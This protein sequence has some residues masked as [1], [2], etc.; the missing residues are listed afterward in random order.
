MKTGSWFIRVCFILIFVLFCM[1]PVGSQPQLLYTL[2]ARIL[3][4][5]TEKAAQDILAWTAKAGGYFTVFSLTSVSIRIPHKELIPL[6]AFLKSLSDDFVQLQPSSRDV[7]LDLVRLESGIV[8]REEILERNLKLFQ[9][10]DYKSTL[11]I[12]KENRSLIEEIER[13]K[14]Q[15][16]ILKLDA[17]YARAEINLA[18]QIQIREQSSR[19]GFEWV[20]NLGLMR[21][22]QETKR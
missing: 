6:V 9:K 5:D 10:A 11:A 8:A 14:T 13:L 21:F 16:S 3:V 22:L 20:Q 1:L 18:F 19:S 15:L 7:T 17:E 4:A 12:E 2:Q